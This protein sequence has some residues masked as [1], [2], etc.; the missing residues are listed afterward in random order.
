MGKLA[1]LGMSGCLAQRV[2]KFK[3]WRR[4][5]VFVCIRVVGETQSIYGYNMIQNMDDK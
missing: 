4:G 1:I 5:H 3:L 2:G